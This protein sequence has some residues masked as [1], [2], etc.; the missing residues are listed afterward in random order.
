[1][2]LPVLA[3]IPVLGA[4]ITGAVSSLFTFTAQVVT[5]R[6]AMVSAAVVILITIISAFHLAISALIDAIAVSMPAEI[7]TAAGMVLPDNAVDC[8]ATVMAAQF[9]RYAMQWK[10]KVVEMKLL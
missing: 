1:M 7:N 2:P 3:G 6:L 8:A 10:T 9:L 4:V 5:K